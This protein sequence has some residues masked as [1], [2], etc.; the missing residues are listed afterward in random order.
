MQALKKADAGRLSFGTEVVTAPD[1]T[2]AALLGASPGASV[3]ANIAL[4]IIQRCF[5]EKLRA[6][7]GY[8]RMKEMLPTFDT[9]LGLPAVPADYTRRS[10]QIDNL[11]QLAPTR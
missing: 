5:P 10:A 8:A 11:L 6:P 2:L 7:E 9:D 1:G 4:E 3:S